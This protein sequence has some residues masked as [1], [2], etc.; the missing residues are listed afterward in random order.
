MLFS[1]D[2]FHTILK[3]RNVQICEDSIFY[4]IE[5]KYVV[6]DIE[7]QISELQV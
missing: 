1:N 6:W 7:K 3:A 5:Q 4:I 2:E